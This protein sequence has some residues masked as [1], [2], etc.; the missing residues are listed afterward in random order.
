M[1]LYQ[2]VCTAYVDQGFSGFLIFFVGC[3]GCFL[4]VVCSNQTGSRRTLRPTWWSTVGNAVQ[5]LEDFIT[6]KSSRQSTQSHPYTVYEIL[7]FHHQ[8]LHCLCCMRVW[9]SPI[10]LFFRRKKKVT[11]LKNWIFFSLSPLFFFRIPLFIYTRSDHSFGGFVETQ[12][13]MTGNAHSRQIA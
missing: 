5:L 11:I 10:L 8:I 2:S 6:K 1:R 4:A 9:K 13:F 3:L 7:R 12:C